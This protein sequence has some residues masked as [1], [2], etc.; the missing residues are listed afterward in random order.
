LQPSTPSIHI[1][2]IIIVVDI[3]FVFIVVIDIA[4]DYVFARRFYS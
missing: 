2:V 4:F 3:V 1:A